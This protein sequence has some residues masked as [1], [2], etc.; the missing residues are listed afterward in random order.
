MYPKR[1]NNNYTSKK[2]DGYI[3]VLF[4]YSREKAK[5]AIIYS[6]NKHINGFAAL[7]EDEEAADIASEHLLSIVTT[8]ENRFSDINHYNKNYFQRQLSL[9]TI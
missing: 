9:V 8:R 1:K 6:Y 5:E 7:L 2:V 4:F 3:I